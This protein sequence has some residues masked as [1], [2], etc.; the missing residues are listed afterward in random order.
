M[1]NSPQEKHSSI[2]SSKNT[3]W[4]VT[5]VAEWS[6]KLRK[7]QNWVETCQFSL[8]RNKTSVV[9]IKNHAKA[10]IKVFWSSIALL[11]LFTFLN[12]FLGLFA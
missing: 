1:L 8:S 4:V 12:I 3:I 2:S 11:D 9:M 5:R 7:S 10:D 6:C